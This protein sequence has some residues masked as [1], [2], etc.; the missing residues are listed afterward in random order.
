MRRTLPMTTTLLA[1]LLLSSTALANPEPSAP[2]VGLGQPALLE[3][4]AA[5]EEAT[6]IL[7]RQPAGRASDVPAVREAVELLRQRGTRAHLP[8]LSSLGLEESPALARAAREA[9]SEVVVRTRQEAR[10]HVAASLSTATP[11]SELSPERTRSD[12]SALGFHEAA[13]LSYAHHFVGPVRTDLLELSAVE[14]ESL[15]LRAEDRENPKEAIRL[16]AAAAAGGHAGAGEALRAHGVDPDLLLLGMVLSPE[17]AWLWPAPREV[18]SGFGTHG[19]DVATAALR[20]RLE[21]AGPR[22]R[23]QSVRTMAMV[24][25]SEAS[26]SDARRGAREALETA[27]ARGGELERIAVSLALDE[28]AQGRPGARIGG[29]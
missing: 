11:W 27:A 19:Q 22:L 6:R 3:A 18:V 15:A 24:L 28:L 21:T 2:A 25:E 9:Y 23:I 7:S 26:S 10:A 17:P 12:G 16:H 13:A 5:L 20:E 14:L 4:D 8:L 29:P 1:A